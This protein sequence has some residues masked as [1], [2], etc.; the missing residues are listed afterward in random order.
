MHIHGL[1]GKRRWIDNYG[2]I[3]WATIKM[4]PDLYKKLALPGEKFDGFGAAIELRDLEDALRKDIKIRVNETIMER[5]R[6]VL[7]V[8]EYLLM[9]NGYLKNQPLSKE[10]RRKAEQAAEKAYQT[11]KACVLQHLKE[12][13]DASGPAI[14]SPANSRK[15]SLAGTRSSSSRSAAS[16]VRRGSW[17]AASSSS[18]SRGSRNSSLYLLSA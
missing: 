18:A 16:P 15:P 9:D 6:N 13:H 1:A 10:A 3:T 7:R 8:M 11:A 4:E 5:A 12:G 17:S 2:K 14:S